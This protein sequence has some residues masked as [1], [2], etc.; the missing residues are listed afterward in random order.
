MKSYLTGYK[1]GKIMKVTV[2]MPVYNAEEFLKETIDSIL[3]QSYKDFEFLIINDGSKDKSVEIIEGYSDERI[4]LIHNEENMGLI[5]TLN[6][7]IELAKGKYI[8][9]MDADDIAEL[10]RLEIQVDYMEKNEDVALVGSNG[11]MFLSKKPMVKKPSNFPT[12]YEDIRCKLLFESTFMH[13]AVMMRRSV[14]IENNYRY[15][16]EYKATEDYGL[17]V[18]IAKEHKVINLPNKLLNYRIVS[19]SITNQA[20]KNMEERVKVMKRIYSVGLD[21]LG[22]EYS[23]EELDIHAEIALSSTLRHFKYTKKSVGEWLE[24][25]MKTNEKTKKYDSVT[26]KKEIAEQYFRISVYNGNYVDYKKSMCAKINPKSFFAYMKAKTAV[27][28][29]QM[30]R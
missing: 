4:R 22:V 28:I 30:V 20:L 11:T 5:K 17:W 8:A 2:L 13:P 6:R 9:R 23:E 16:L 10:N 19:S 3:N 1:G 7:G 12:K 21:D 18:E 24:K 25:L 14:L 15:R 26:F 29:K 27:K